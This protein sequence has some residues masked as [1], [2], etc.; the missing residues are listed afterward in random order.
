MNVD[1]VRRIVRELI[2]KNDWELLTEDDLVGLVLNSGSELTATEV[3]RVATHHYSIAMYNAC[4]GGE[5][6]ERRERGY[7]EL[8]RYLYR[9]AYN[10]WPQI[11][12]DAT[13]AALL[14][15]LEQ[16]D[17][18]RHPGTFL[19]FALYKLWGAFKTQ[20]P[21]KDDDE[22]LE[23]IVEIVSEGEAADP[24]VHLDRQELWQELLGAIRR[25]PNERQQKAI[26][27]KYCAGLSDSEIAEQLETSVGN[28]GVLRH[29]GIV[30]GLRRD[31]GLRSYFE[32]VSGAPL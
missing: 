28:V 23:T 11:A 18:C 29:R 19:A 9:A 6:P 25:L 3:K 26:L 32:S 10:K 22:L 12:E 30:C 2:Q 4:R 8:H 7:L 31:G 5:G 1:A 15:V 21:S 20:A 27:L 16:I 14:K 17:R 13:Q 24:E